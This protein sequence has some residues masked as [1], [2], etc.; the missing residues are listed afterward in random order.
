MNEYPNGL[1]ESK[2]GKCSYCGKFE[3]AL[4]EQDLCEKC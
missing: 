1:E 2:S 4:Y 3:E